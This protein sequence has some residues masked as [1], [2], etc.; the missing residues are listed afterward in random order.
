MNGATPSPPRPSGEAAPAPETSGRRLLSSVARARAAYRRAKIGSGRLEPVYRSVIR[1]ARAAV[2]E[3]DAARA[4]TTWI[5]LIKLWLDDDD[6]VLVGRPEQALWRLAVAAGG[7]AFRA[8]CVSLRDDLPLVFP[9]VSADPL[10]PRR[11]AL[12]SRRTRLDR[13]YGEA[14]AADGRHEFAVEAGFE[15][16]RR[17]AYPHDAVRALHRAG[18][19]FDA[20]AVAREALASPTTVGV[21]ALRLL[22][23]RLFPERGVRRLDVRA[24]ESEFLARPTREGFDAY[25]RSI[26]PDQRAA[27]AS[28]V[29]MVLQRTQREPSLVFELYL[30]QDRLLDADGMATTQRVSA[31]TLAAGADRIL[32]SHP[33][34]AAGWLLVAAHRLA[35]AAEPERRAAAVPLL[36][37]VRDLSAETGRTEDFR[38]ALGRLKSRHADRPAFLK[39]LKRHGL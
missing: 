17:E 33:A 5:A 9:A 30:E 28:R 7:P 27:A 1:A 4:K 39:L 38:R 37:R 8:A 2:G 24:T 12:L 6:A 22:V 26:P 34:M 35:D 13:L 36:V 3:P 32:P 11:I 18:R 23:D 21:E 10:D 31:E 16:L 19:T 25:V 29:L 15:R 20:L 14:L